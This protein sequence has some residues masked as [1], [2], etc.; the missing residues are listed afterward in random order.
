MMKANLVV[1]Q[2]RLPFF[3]GTHTEKSTFN[4][5]LPPDKISFIL[6]ANGSGKSTLLK[7]LLGVVPPDSGVLKG[8][9]APRQMAWLEQYTVNDIAYT[10][11]EIIDM[12]GGTL[13]RV[14]ESITLFKVADLLPKRLDKMSGG[15]Q[16]RLHLARTYAQG[17]SWL[18]MDEPASNLDI[19]HEIDF[20]ELLPK[21]VGGQ[22]VLMSTHQ[23]HHITSLPKHLRG[24]VLV[25]HEGSLVH[26]CDGSVSDTWIENYAEALNI[27]LSVLLHRLALPPSPF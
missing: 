22:S 1:E 21:I 10:G 9:R 5:S 23:P 8:A 7:V 25:L 4:F 3:N 14:N 24:Q 17:A 2:L 20:L 11:K 27:E 12:S 18:L 16:R 6:G 26:A 15:Q 19:A 13:A